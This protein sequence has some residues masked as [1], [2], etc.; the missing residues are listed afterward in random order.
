MS[1]SSYE[2]SERA[3]TLELEEAQCEIDRLRDALIHAVSVI[4]AWHNMGMI[5]KQAS[6][7]WDIYWRNAPEMKQIRLALDPNPAF[8]EQKS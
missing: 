4:Q 3:G 6:D 2:R 7:M 8:Q 1:V 5:G